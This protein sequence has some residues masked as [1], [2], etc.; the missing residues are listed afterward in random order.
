LLLPSTT[1][2]SSQSF[3]TLFHKFLNK[4]KNNDIIINLK[5]GDNYVYN[6]PCVYH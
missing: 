5:R 6:H 1:S 2:A 3:L 4:K